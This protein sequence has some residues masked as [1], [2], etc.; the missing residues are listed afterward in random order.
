[1]F[2]ETRPTLVF[3]TF[4]PNFLLKRG[5][6][7]CFVVCNAA[8]GRASAATGPAASARRASTVRPVRFG[9]TD[10]QLRLALLGRL[11]RRV[12]LKTWEF[13]VILNYQNPDNIENL[14]RIPG[15]YFR[16]SRFP[17]GLDRTC[18]L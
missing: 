7:Y 9:F 15:C 6:K 18:R 16:D 13:Y 14:Q 10:G 12:D 8:G 3:F 11:N 1:M 17:I 2:P 4:E 5:P